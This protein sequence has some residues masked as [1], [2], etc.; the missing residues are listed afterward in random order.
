MSHSPK[1]GRVSTTSSNPDGTWPNPTRVVIQRNPGSGSGWRRSLLLDL[2]RELKRRGYRPRMFR[3]RARC[4]RWLS[5]PVNRAETLCLVAAGGDGTVDD[6]VNRHP[7]WPLAIL[8]LGTE[9]LLARGLGIV[10]SGVNL[11]KV[12]AEGHRRTIDLGLACDRRFVLMASVGFDAEVIRRVH[13][14]RKGTISH[15][16]YLQPIWA[17]LR[18]YNYPRLRVWIDDEPQPREAR[19]AVIVNF[20]MYALNLPIAKQ[21]SADDGW[22]DVRLF[23]RGSAFQI[24]RYFCTLLQGRHETLSDVVSVRA[25]RVRIESESSAPVQVDGDPHG[26]TPIEIRVIEHALQ[27]FA[28]RV[29]PSPPATEAPRF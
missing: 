2:V 29:L 14:E 28:P 9:N 26:T 7:G 13:S 3:D 27:V 8:P 12:I 1:G 25:R 24:V 22:L 4:D 18:S 6:L 10:P 17:A 11:A 23:Q 20:P 16:S 19:L 15:L 21:A 5:E